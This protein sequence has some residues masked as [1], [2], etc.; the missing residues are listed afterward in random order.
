MVTALQTSLP[1][2]SLPD[3]PIV[4]ET[5]DAAQAARDAQ[6][7]ADGSASFLRLV[8]PAGPS[9]VLVVEDHAAAG[10]CASMLGAARSL[11]DYLPG[12]GSLTETGAAAGAL[13]SLAVV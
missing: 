7:C 5:D 2:P 10:S 11:K 4:P 9:G 6:L 3:N 13:A 12:R 8:S 1:S